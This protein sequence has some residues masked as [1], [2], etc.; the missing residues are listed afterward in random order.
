MILL[1]LKILWLL[2]YEVGD[3]KVWNNE[4][5]E[6]CLLALDEI[7]LLALGFRK[8]YLNIFRVGAS[9]KVS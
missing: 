3:H 2:G 5:I 6:R 9:G 8:K 1:S 7:V 4:D